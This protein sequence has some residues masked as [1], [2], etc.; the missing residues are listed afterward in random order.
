M[1]S[2]PKNFVPVL[3][4]TTLHCT[5]DMARVDRRLVMGNRVRARV[6]MPRA[7]H[8]AVIAALSIVGVAP[9]Q[10][11]RYVNAAAPAGGNGLTWLTAFNNLQT[12]LGVATTNPAI[13][14]LWVAAGIYKPAVP[15][16]S[17]TAT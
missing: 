10:G 3:L 15:G 2:H 8:C 6:S 13:S 14:E 16:G 9:A 1:C 4:A 11:V 7:M 12:A 17:R 5:M